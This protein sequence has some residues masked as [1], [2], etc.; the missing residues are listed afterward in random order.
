VRH[1]ARVSLLPAPLLASFI[2]SPNWRGKEY[3][4]EG[5]GSEDD[6][7]FKVKVGWRVRG[8][9]SGFSISERRLQ[10]LLPV[11]PAIRCPATQRF[12][13]LSSQTPLPSSSLLS[14]P[15][16]LYLSGAVHASA[17]P[18]CLW[19]ELRG[20]GTPSAPRLP[21][22]SSTFH[23]TSPPPSY[24]PGFLACSY[25]KRLCMCLWAHPTK[26]PPALQAF[27]LQAGATLVFGE[28]W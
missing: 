5:R 22:L 6:A 16:N 26:P 17:L 11:G 7:G 28:G 21:L 2:S 15:S 18:Y 1:L 9:G 13:P 27:P 10:S 19:N 12:R 23:L 4:W 8:E 3:F 24:P 25:T 20:R 14:S